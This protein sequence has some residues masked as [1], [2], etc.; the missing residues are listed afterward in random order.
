MAF[1]W[2]NGVLDGFYTGK[3]GIWSG[4]SGTFSWALDGLQ[5]CRFDPSP[6]WEEEEEEEE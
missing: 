3:T 5:G 1:Y 6:E 4:S 2:K